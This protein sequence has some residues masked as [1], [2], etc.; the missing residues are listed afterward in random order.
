MLV[1]TTD[2]Q[3][4]S[5][6]LSTPPSAAAPTFSH[7][8]QVDDS[9]LPQSNSDDSASSTPPLSDLQPTPPLS[10]LS[11]PFNDLTIFSKTSRIDGI[12]HHVLGNLDRAFVIENDYYRIQAIFDGHGSKLN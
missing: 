2:L 6:P 8:P 5:Q 4:C 1:T 11:F 3:S 10:Q 7:P 9:E 12:N